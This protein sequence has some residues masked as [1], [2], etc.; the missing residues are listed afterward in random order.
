MTTTTTGF[1]NF[2]PGEHRQLLAAI[3]R[4]ARTNGW[5]WHE[6]W[7]WVNARY[8]SEA[9]LGVEWEDGTVVIRSGEVLLRSKTYPV[10]GVRQAVDLL[11][12]LDILPARYT[13][14]YEAGWHD[15]YFADAE[16]ETRAEIKASWAKPEVAR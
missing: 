12:A 14:A 6:C 15:G 9:T 1:T 5:N 4:W 13:R 8:A 3:H 10:D 11:F 2:A 16:D 7:G